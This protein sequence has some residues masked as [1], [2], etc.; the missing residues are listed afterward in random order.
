MIDIA[1]KTEKQFHYLIEKAQVEA[2]TDKHL[3]FFP[4]QLW[5]LYGKKERKIHYLIEKVEVEANQ[6]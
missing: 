3:Q 6:W 4:Y 5:T 1:G 2:N